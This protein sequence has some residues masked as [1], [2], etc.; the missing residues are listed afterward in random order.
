MQSSSS[1]HC[2]EG[3]YYLRLQGW[4]ITNEKQEGYLFPLVVCTLVS[5]MSQTTF[6]HPALIVTIVLRTVTV[7]WKSQFSFADTKTG[8]LNSTVIICRAKYCLELHKC[9]AVSLTYTLPDN[10]MA[11][12]QKPD[13]VF[14]L[15]GRVH[16]NRRGCQ[17][18]W[19]LAA[20]MRASADSEHIIFS[21]YVDRSLKM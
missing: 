4:E 5:L 11:H 20:E 16:L 13:L 3:T 6:C 9:H 1:L 12:A 10:V 7:C 2:F 17:F 14:Q 8:Q 21:K 15:N 19:L 18:S